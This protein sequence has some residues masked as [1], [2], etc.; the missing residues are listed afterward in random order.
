MEEVQ[1]QV[2]SLPRLGQPAPAF[3]AVTTH[4]VLK[5][6]DFKEGWLIL[7]S[8]RRISRQYAPLSSSPLPKFTQNYRSAGW[9]FWD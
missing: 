2:I 1:Q 6:E 9:S 4:V 7:F 5:L 8:T 3:E